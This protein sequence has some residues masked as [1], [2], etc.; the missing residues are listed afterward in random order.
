MGLSALTQKVAEKNAW[1]LVSIWSTDPGFVKEHY[2]SLVV[3]GT[4]TFERAYE[5]MLKVWRENYAGGRCRLCG[6]KASACAP[7]HARGRSCA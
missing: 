5:F 6:G 7:R 2:P 4:L 3:D 1:D